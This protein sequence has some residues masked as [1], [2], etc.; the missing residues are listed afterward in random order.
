MKSSKYAERF[1][2]IKDLTS[3]TPKI[4]KT[5]AIAAEKLDIS[6]RQICRIKN[7]FDGTVNSLMHGN[8]GNSN[9][10]IFDDETINKIIDYTRALNNKL[11]KEGISNYN[12]SYLRSKV[13]SQFGINIS[14]TRLRQLMYDHNISSPRLHFKAHKS[15]MHLPCER[16]MRLKPGEEWQIDGTFEVYLSG[17][18][19]S[20]CAHVIVDA[21]T[22]VIIAIYLDYQ[23]TTNGY[24]NCLK[25]GFEQYGTP[26]RLA[27]DR[28]PS[29]SNN[30]QE[31][32]RHAAIAEICNKLNIQNR[33]TSNPRGK[34][35]VES[36]NAVVKDSI[37]KD[38][39]LSGA[40]TIEEA[41]RIL[42]TIINN[43][44][45]HFGNS[46]ALE[47]DTLH[48]PLSSN[49]NP[50]ELFSKKEMR[51]ISRNNTISLEKT[52]YILIN[53]KTKTIL[54]T[55]H[56]KNIS[57]VTIYTMYN[58][59]R[60]AKFK[61]V[62]YELVLA[63][64]EN[65]VDI[66]DYNLIIEDRK[67]LR[68]KVNISFH[69]KQ[70]YFINNDGSVA[71]FKHGTPVKLMY[72]TSGSKYYP[73]KANINNTIYIV[74]EGIP[75]IDDN[76]FEINTYI[77]KDSLIRVNDLYYK[78]VNSNNVDITVKNNQQVQVELKNRIPQHGILSNKKFNLVLLAS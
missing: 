31:P 27:S 47:Q 58:G 3:E 7:N 21:A 70:Y 13:F 25:Q 16:N 15:Q 22:N 72:H 51:K 66:D 17:G 75:T 74:K 71:E 6:I 52:T 68:N 46:F 64:Q 20:Y 33:L 12:Y 24:F 30:S 61:N 5:N 57:K 40:T 67:I 35:K 19:I 23:E 73:Q 77:T 55:K 49:Y 62:K 18:D 1:E 14:Y 44:N 78:L 43:I 50:E 39:I 54:K 53:P 26:N 59:Q 36:K 37:M 45:K 56:S 10:L 63:T 41:N 2:V 60:F 76:T 9:H 4:Y 8:K 38:L 32:K 48:K 11:Q 65:V 69:K 28:H 29:F 42:P 34:N